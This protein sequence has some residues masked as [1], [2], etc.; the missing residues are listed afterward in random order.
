MFSILFVFEIIFLEHRDY[1]KKFNQP[2]DRTFAYRKIDDRKHEY[3]IQCSKEYDWGGVRNCRQY[4]LSYQIHAGR[5]Y[6]A[7]VSYD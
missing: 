1:L 5:G 7:R 6:L 4:T 2:C 3:Q